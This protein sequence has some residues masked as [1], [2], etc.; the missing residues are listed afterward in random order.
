MYIHGVQVAG[1]RGICW[2]GY[3]LPTVR[4]SEIHSELSAGNLGNR[5]TYAHRAERSQL[6][7]WEIHTELRAGNLG[8]TL[9]AH[10]WKPGGYTLKAHS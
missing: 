6:E 5:D 2:A 3:L 9:K 1:P 10:S 8:D 7:T 4:A